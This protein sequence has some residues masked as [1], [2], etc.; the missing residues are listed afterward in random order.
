MHNL[1]DCYN[2]SKIF[3][4]FWA[5]LSSAEWLASRQLFDRAGLL[6]WKVLSLRRSLINFT[7]FPSC[8]AGPF[9]VRFVL[10]ARCLSAATL[11][12]SPGLWADTLALA[13]ITF[14]CIYMSQRTCFG[15]DGSDQMAIILTVGALIM[16]IGLAEQRPYFSYAG[17]LLVGGQLVLSYFVAGFAKLVSTQ[18]R[19]GQAFG[20]VM[21]TQ[22]YGHEG[23][24][25]IVA[26]YS[27]VSAAVCWTVILGEVL[28]PL[29]LFANKNVLVF[30]LG[31]FA[32]FHV[33][34]AFFMGLNAFVIAFLGCYPSVL[35][36]QES[37]K[38]AIDRSW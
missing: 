38:N 28:F 1:H 13:V 21:L 23:A 6:S 27:A 9:A 15:I 29:A 4:A 3:V 30:A 2:T 19:H 8:L 35:L 24:T 5:L 32:L 11:F 33:A 22:T 7:N 14:S 37:I 26:R 16:A 20:K 10:I 31:C 12:I 34:N 18:W 36:L 25:R 17:V